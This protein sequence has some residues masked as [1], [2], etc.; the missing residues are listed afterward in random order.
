MDVMLKNLSRVQ[1]VGAWAAMV[2]ILMSC[3]VV[4]GAEVSATAAELWLVA[5]VVPPV[6]M[7]FVWRGARAATV[8]G[9]LYAVDPASADVRR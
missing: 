1:W 4:A 2:I 5:G 6:V 3:S 7:L 9:M 8:T